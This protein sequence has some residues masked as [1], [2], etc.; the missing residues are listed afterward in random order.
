MKI[1]RAKLALEGMTPRRQLPLWWHKLFL[2]QHRLLHFVNTLEHYML[3]YGVEADWDSMLSKVVSAPDIDAIKELHN[4]YLSAIT[5]RCLLQPKAAKLHEIVGTVLSQSICTRRLY[6]RAMQNLQGSEVMQ[7]LLPEI[8][9]LHDQFSNS[10]RLFLMITKQLLKTKR[11]PY[12][13][14]ILL[15]LDL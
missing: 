7:A 6:D 14:D 8:Q 13:E 12:L 2:L 3:N 10:S 15:R 5:T 9:K 1:K 4:V 11:L